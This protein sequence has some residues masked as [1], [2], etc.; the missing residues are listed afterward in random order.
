MN[1]EKHR[2]ARFLASARRGRPTEDVTPPAWLVTSILHRWKP[3]SLPESFPSLWLR[4]SRWG[5]ACA[6]AMGVLIVAFQHQA[7][8]TPVLAEFAGLL[9]DQNDLE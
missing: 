4:W 8:A 9:E 3:L 1:S 2:L 6:L 7:P 5:A